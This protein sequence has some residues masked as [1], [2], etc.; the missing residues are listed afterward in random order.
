MALWLV[1]AGSA[2]ER[3]EVALQSRVVTIG[4]SRW[5]KLGDLSSIQTKEELRSIYERTV[6][7]SKK[8]TAS[9]DIGQIWTFVDRIK[10]DDFVVLPLKLRSGIAIG[11]ITGPYQYKTDSPSEITHF[12]SVEWIKTDLPRTAFDQDLLY[13]FGAFMTVCQ[14]QRN[15]AEERVRAIIKGE[16]VTLAE[17]EKEEA[18]QVDVE[19]QA[20]DQILQFVNQRFKGH[21]LARLVE[22]ILRAEGYFT[23][24]SPPGPDE[25]VDI[26][27]GRGPMGFEKPRVCVQVK[28]SESPVDVTILREL[29]GSMKNFDADQ[30]LLVSIGGFKRTVEEEAK[31][32]FF[33]V[34]LWDS[35]GL[36]KSLFDNY[37]NLPATIQKELPLKRMWGLVPDKEE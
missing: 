3:E 10:P 36:L 28:S 37:E 34:R 14:I 22:S 8:N 23:K 24:I 13:S 33:T 11:K 21:D 2:G 17:E 19:Q 27:A 30:G 18:G 15:N 26:L 7:E 1:R 16:K 29:Q 25:G 12:R 9:N 32:S 5:N 6:P 20:R 4:G 31:R 35:E